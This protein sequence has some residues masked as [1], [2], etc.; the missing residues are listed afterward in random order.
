VNRRRKRF[1][2]IGQ[3][4]RVRQGSAQALGSSICHVMHYRYEESR[5]AKFYKAFCSQQEQFASIRSLA[6]H[7]HSIIFQY[8]FAGG[9]IH[10]R[11]PVAPANWVGR[12]LLLNPLRQLERDVNTASLF[13]VFKAPRRASL[14]LILLKMSAVRFEKSPPDGM[15]FASRRCQR[16]KRREVPGSPV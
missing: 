9:R 1:A 2:G 10:V 16:R 8:P 3:K 11:R 7:C 6:V 14:E 4:W 5:C 15:A 13:D 12:P